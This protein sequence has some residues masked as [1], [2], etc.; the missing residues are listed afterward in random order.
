VPHS[1]G[2]D[3][4]FARLVDIG[5]G[6][7][8]EMTVKDGLGRDKAGVRDSERGPR[9]G[10]LTPGGL[11]ALHESGGLAA[12]REDL[13]GALLHEAVDNEEHLESDSAA[14]HHGAFGEGPKDDVC[15]LS[16]V[17]PGINY[18]A[19]HVLHFGRSLSLL[20]S[21]RAGR[22]SKGGSRGARKRSRIDADLA[23]SLLL[24]CH[25]VVQREAA[26]MSARAGTAASG[27]RRAV[28]LGAVGNRPCGWRSPVC[29]SART[30]VD[31]GALQ[32]RSRCDLQPLPR[33]IPSPA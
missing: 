22:L 18:K 12:G 30:G 2:V 5:A 28:E 10:A 17:L 24:Y 3:S 27:I 32:K 15:G 14:G 6:V 16:A 1:A 31:T 21:K 26:A 4:G 25:G 33:P 7:V 13:E 23:G 20:P 9:V 8:G 19:T 11:D 29:A